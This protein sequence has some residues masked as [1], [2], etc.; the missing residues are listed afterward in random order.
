MATIK[1]FEDIQAWITARNLSKEVFHIFQSEPA[2]WDFPLK[3]QVNSSLGSV[4]DNIA[5]G[6]ERGGSKEFIQF[7]FISKGSSGESRSQI[8]RMFDRG[9]I[10]KAE[11]D[12]FI[13]EILGISRQIM[14]LIMYLKKSEIKGDK[15]KKG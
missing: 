14:G 9:Y 15:F 8:Y 3:D 4:M 11:F 5:E 7:L 12:H 10:S 1:Q 6:F 2:K 13:E